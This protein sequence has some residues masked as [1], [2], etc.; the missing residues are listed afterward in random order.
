MT[1]HR[2]ALQPT[3]QTRSKHGPT[4]GA[5]Y[6]VLPVITSGP[7]R[8]PCA[9]RAPLAGFTRLEA[10]YRSK[11]TAEAQGSQVLPP[12]SFLA[13]R[14][15]YSGSHAGAYALYFPARISLLYLSRR[16]A[17]IPRDT[18]LSL[19]RTLPA[20]PVRSDFTELHHSPND[21]GLRF[22]LAPLTGEDPLEASR[23]GTL[24]GQVQPVHYCTNPPPAYTSKR[25]I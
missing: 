21:Y 11:S 19:T 25:A 16:S 24:S 4:L 22:W 20:I 15:P 14:W 10:P 5:G 12:L 1:I 7:L 13:C 8:L 6:V 9:R 23:L 17:C 3:D 2:S 18:D